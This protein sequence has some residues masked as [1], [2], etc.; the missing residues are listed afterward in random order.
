MAKVIGRSIDCSRKVIG[1]L[2]GSMRSLVYDVE[3]PDGAV[4]QYAANV[5]A[6]N[7]LSQVDASG[8]HSQHLRKIVAHER[9]PEALDESD[10]YITT[11]RGAR[12]QRQFTVGWRFFCEWV[13]GTS[14]WASLK[15]LKESNPIEVAEY[16]V[17]S[18]F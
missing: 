3:F 17:A 8:F 9:S 15:V 13:D 2:D 7:V 14:S 16:A 6:E 5:I 10:A 11:N 12:R 18:G 1:D 4:K